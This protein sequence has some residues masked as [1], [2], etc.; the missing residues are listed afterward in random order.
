MTL[1]P[2]YLALAEAQQGVGNYEAS[3][4][5]MQ[6][7]L[8]FE[9]DDGQGWQLLGLGYQ[10]TDEA[11]LAMDA[12]ER[13]LSIDPNLP[14]AAFYRGAQRLEAGQN[15]AALG[16]LRIAVVGEPGWFEARIYLAQAYLATG[17]PSSAFFEINASASQARSDEQRA[18]LFYWRATSLD[19]LGQPENARPDWQSLI[20]LPADVVPAEWRAVALARLQGQ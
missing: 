7:F 15:E 1:L 6:R 17:S 9:G 8:G 14:Q 16:D 19:A 3:I 18:M 10:F 12:F 4:E 2:N 11:E 20:D 13:A 5:T